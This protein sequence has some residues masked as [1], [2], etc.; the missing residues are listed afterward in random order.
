MEIL[1]LS[2]K[3]RENIGKKTKVLRKKDILPAV[4][5]GPKIK[6]QP[7]E[8]DAKEFKK[9]YEEVG[10]SSLISLGIKKAGLDKKTNSDK[11]ETKKN[12]VLVHDIKKDPLTDEIIHVDF[13]QPIL[14]EEV[15]VTVPLVF[16]GTAPAVKDLG[17]TLVKEI[18]EL[19][20]K[21]FPQD[22]PHD[23]KAN[24]EG[25]KTF[26]DEILIKDLNIPKGVKVMREQNEI[27]ALVVPPTK[28]EE[29]LAKPI[30]EKVEEIE[31]VEKENKE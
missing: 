16:E 28:V 11:E 17:G 2:A 3:I 20:V 18:Q 13:Y 31:K 24:I 21:A 5:Y 30:E 29:E 10:E 27:V 7:L 8:I 4:L 1:T 14:T 22:L 25:L 26:D 12:L 9:I 15:E 23:I 6:P 19:K